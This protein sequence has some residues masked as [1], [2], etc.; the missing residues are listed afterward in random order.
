[1]TV[2]EFLPPEDLK[3]FRERERFALRELK[4]HARLPDRS[5]LLCLQCLEIPITAELD[6]DLTTLHCWRDVDFDVPVRDRAL[7]RWNESRHGRDPDFVP[8]RWMQTLFERVGEEIAPC[9]FSRAGAVAFALARG[10]R[11]DKYR[12]ASKDL[13]RFVL[14]FPDL[15]TM[16]VRRRDG[17]VLHKLRQVPTSLFEI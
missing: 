4:D 6:P 10:P 7:W 5:R 14:E 17:Q 15:E 16:V 2:E 3:V 11:G 12:F 9:A 8:P 13:P 1:M